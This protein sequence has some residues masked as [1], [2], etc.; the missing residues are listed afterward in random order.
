[1][2]GIY[3][4]D[5]GHVAVA[6]EV[7]PI[8]ELGV[9]FNAELD[10]IDNIYLLGT[11]MGLSLS[12]VGARLDDI[13][14]FAELERFAR[15]KLQHFS[16][17]MIARLA[18][19]VAFSAVRDVLILDEIFAV[20]DA[21][22]QARCEERYRELIAAG[23]TVIL[24]S[25]DPEA[26]ATMCSRAVLIEGGRVVLDGDASSVADQYVAMLSNEGT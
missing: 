7:T 20:G 9:G 13:L 19:A 14:R 26:I 23:H 21:G 22:F 17:G 16:S 6:D 10:A 2:A 11:V 18:Y 24:V 5:E 1:V 15:Q 25:H 4:A 3:E 12:Q 8:L